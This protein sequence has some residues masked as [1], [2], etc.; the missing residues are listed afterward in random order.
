MTNFHVKDLS[1][2]KGSKTILKPGM[3][4]QQTVTATVFAGSNTFLDVFLSSWWIRN[5]RATVSAHWV[6]LYETQRQM[7][8][9]GDK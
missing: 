7:E 8:G 4:M 9:H 1:S 6:S 2:I 3:L 5:V